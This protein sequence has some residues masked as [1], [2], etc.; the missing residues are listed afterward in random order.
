MFAVGAAGL[1]A[2]LAV[3]FAGMPS[4]GG[5]ISEYARLLN[6][7]AQQQR[8]VTDV[9]SAISFDYRG[10][11][12]LFE[13][14]ILFSAVAGISVLLRPL[15]EEVRQLPEEKAPDRRIPPPSPAVGMLGVILSP[16]LVVIG[17]E[18]V[19]HGQLSPGGGF[20]GGVVLASGL[21]VVFLAT[22]YANADRYQP[23]W[24]LDAAE[25]AGAGGYVLI[26]LLGLLAGSAYLANV[27]GLGRTGNLIS[28]GTIALLNVVVG[29]EV[30]AGFALL[31][32]H[33]LDQTAVIR[34]GTHRPGRA[35]GGP[36]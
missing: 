25:G 16:L 2:S 23:K 7:L 36:A 33:F 22:D 15:A 29:V 4:F 3:A 6:R 14:F 5:P 10:I 27:V 24:L 35:G 28:G 31:G 11:D 12:T 30:A 20:Q 19:T 26:G 1:A 17:I 34:S 32:A 8:R 18:T 21:F 13:E 9:V